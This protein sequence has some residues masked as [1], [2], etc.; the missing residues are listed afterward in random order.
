MAGKVRHLLLRG[1]RYY[2]RRIGP[3][4][5]R[6]FI[7]KN[8]LRIPLGSDR[9][10]AIGQLPFA[11][12]KISSLIDH[13]GDALEAR[14][15]NAEV[16]VRQHSPSSRNLSTIRFSI[17]RHRIQRSVPQITSGRLS[18]WL[19]ENAIDRLPHYPIQ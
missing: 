17:R 10:E 14:A 11:L 1:G 4:E 5:L 7:Q 16:G 15:A 6:E 2:A 8:E 3:K 9:R 12:V 13:A 18:T 19:R